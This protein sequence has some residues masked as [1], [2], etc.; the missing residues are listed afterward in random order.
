MPVPRIVRRL[1]I[2]PGVVL[3]ALLV[4]TSLPLL[5][6]AAA[7]A[8]PL[9][10]GRMRALR[11]L[12][13][14]L[15][16]LALEASLLIVLGV[17]W[18]AAVFGRRMRS[19][20]MQRIHYRLAAWF[21]RVLMSTARH[22][23]KLRIEV[24]GS[25]PPPLPRV[26]LIVLARHAGPGDS[27]LLLHQLMNAE[28]RQPRIVLKDALQW[29]ALIDIALNRLPAHFISTSGP[30]AGVVEAIA[31]LASGMDADDALVIFPEGG[32]FTEHR[33][34]RS[35]AKLE[36][37]GRH[38]EARRARELDHLLAPRSGG[39][40]AALAG[41]P[42][43]DVVFVAHTGLEDL[44]TVVDLWRGLPLDDDIDIRMWHVPAA[45]VP[46]SEA[47]RIEWL[48][49]WWRRMDEWIS[50]ERPRREERHGSRDRARH[51][52]R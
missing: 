37:L 7:L 8:S 9:L 30:G 17:L 24:H 51:G 12:V 43:A 23:F 26:P 10:P 47:E 25:W 41:C 50:T 31:Q 28:R 5:V 20:R 48:G 36:E 40:L 42:T 39:V 34:L 45:D 13:F 38:E 18:L 14:A 19:P 27:F 35:I 44:S 15:V 1:L 21:L 3:V 46:A 16:Y 33:R 4:F 2:A 29:D 52:G 49:A 6:L 22:A 11:V 32:N